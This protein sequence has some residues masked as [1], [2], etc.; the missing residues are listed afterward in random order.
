MYRHNDINISINHI[1][2]IRTSCKSRTVDC[3]CAMS[4]K[5]GVHARTRFDGAYDDQANSITHLV[6][7]TFSISAV[8]PYR[9]QT[10][11]ITSKCEST[12][13]HTVRVAINSKIVPGLKS[14]SVTD[15]CHCGWSGM[16]LL[17]ESRYEAYRRQAQGA[18]RELI[19]VPIELDTSAEIDLND[20]ISSQTSIRT[21]HRLECCERP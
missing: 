7:I 1:P 3:S 20:D 21:F 6:N 18:A 4:M 16:R 17:N 13:F 2:Y 8:T 11:H 19:F 5:Y 14:D 10:R 15:A 12:R 9:L